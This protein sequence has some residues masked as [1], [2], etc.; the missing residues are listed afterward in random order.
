MVQNPILRGFHPDPSLLRVGDDYYL[1]TSTF[2]WAPGVRIYHSTDLKHWDYVT[3][4][5]DDYF[6]M[7][8]RGLKASDGIWAPCLSWDGEYFYLIYTV[9]RDAREFPVMDTPNYLIR[10]KK[11]TGPWSDPVYLNSSGFDP[12]LFHDEDGRKWLVNMEWDYRKILSGENSFTGILLQ[13]YDPE[14][15]ALVGEAKKIFTGSPIGGTEGPHLY[16][17]N[18]YYYLM[19]AEGGTGWFHAVTLARSRELTGP[20]EICPHNPVLTSWE[21]SRDPKEIEKA[22]AKKDLGTS[23][24]KKAGHASLVEGPDNRWFLAHLCGRNLPGMLYCPLGRETA[25]QEVVWEKGWLKLKDGGSA[26]KDSFRAIGDSDAEEKREPLKKEYH[27][28]DESFLEDFQTL[29]VFYRDLGMTIHEREGYLRIYGRDSI[30]SRYEQALLARRQM[31]LSFEAAVRFEFAPTSFQHGAG[32]S[33]RYDER[34]QYYAYVTLGDKGVELNLLSV[35][36]GKTELLASEPVKGLAGGELP[37]YELSVS[38]EAD[39]VQFFWLDETSEKRKLGPTLHS[40][41]LS[42]DFADG[43]TGAFVGVAVQDMKD[44]KNY[45]DVAW[46]KYEERDAK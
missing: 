11:L 38:V 15:K 18:G 40:Y 34:N 22:L 46:F 3:S 21:G 36:A 31:E 16:R 26:P 1:A 42:D 9:V 14:K 32:L 24:L 10:A 6:R 28:Q 12:S 39:A 2:E 20:Y 17:H 43:F 30:F 41:I 13:E 35:I 8:L 37:A 25:I 4:P 33:Y 19:C 5:L 23:F 45:A 7:D 27:F 44:R 29:R